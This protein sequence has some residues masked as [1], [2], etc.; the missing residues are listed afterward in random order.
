[1]DL[2]KNDEYLKAYVIMWVCDIVIMGKSIYKNN[3][4]YVI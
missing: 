2:L 4:M 3:H 1:M